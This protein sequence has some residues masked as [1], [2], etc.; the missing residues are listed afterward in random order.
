MNKCQGR[1]D[2]N[3]IQIH[4]LRTRFAVGFRKINWNYKLGFTLG[5][6][7]YITQPIIR[8]LSLLSGGKML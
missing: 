8:P 6:D 5:A 7:Q 2:F 3:V 1:I 4:V